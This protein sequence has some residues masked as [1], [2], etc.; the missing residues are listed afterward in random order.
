MTIH[1]LAALHLRTEKTLKSR[2]ADGSREKPVVRGVSEARGADKVEISD[3][4]RLLASQAEETPQEREAEVEERRELSKE[5][6]LE[7]RRWIAD[8]FYELP[9]TVAEVAQR[10]LA[11]GDLDI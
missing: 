4:A 9:T 8:G 2:D 11:S 6:V 5:Q 3:E 7:I 1:D 10:I